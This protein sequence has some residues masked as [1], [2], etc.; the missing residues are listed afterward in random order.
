MSIIE[1]AIWGAGTGIGFIVFMCILYML[2]NIR[3]VSLNNRDSYK[4]QKC[5]KVWL[6]LTTY[7]H[8]TLTTLQTVGRR[9]TAW[10]FTI[11]GGF[12]QALFHLIFYVVLCYHPVKKWKPKIRM[13]SG[14]ASPLLPYSVCYLLSQAFPLVFM[15]TSLLQYKEAE[16]SLL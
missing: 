4:P 15:G 1:S 7:I 3:R 2:V 11:F 14:L 13:L 9:K 8:Y 5:Y 10:I 16:M 12:C 6:H